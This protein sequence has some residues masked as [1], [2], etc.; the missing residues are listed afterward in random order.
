MRLV[1][2]Q[3]EHFVFGCNY[4][5]YREV[6]RNFLVVLQ[7]GEE[8]VPS[9]LCRMFSVGRR[10]ILHISQSGPQDAGTYTCHVGDLN[11]SA[12]LRVLG[13]SSQL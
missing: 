12:I 13:K 5:H 3:R 4:S 1:D 9:T 11:A 2:F 6:L 10:R 8:L 7:D